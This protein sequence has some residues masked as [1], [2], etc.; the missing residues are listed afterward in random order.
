MKGREGE[1]GEKDRKKEA[2]GG[3]I[4]RGKVGKEGRK[5]QWRRKG[6]EKRWKG[7]D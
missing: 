5:G 7:E 6:E 2:R 1:R 4:R 3:T